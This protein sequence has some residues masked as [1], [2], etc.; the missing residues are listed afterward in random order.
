[1]TDNKE[2][3]RRERFEQMAVRLANYRKISSATTYSSLP[4]G[5]REIMEGMQYCDVVKPLMAFDREKGMTIRGLSIKY[6]L[7]KTTVA[8]YLDKIDKKKKAAS[9][10]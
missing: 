5:V 7:P 10:V 8:S 6:G 2:A 4:L 1:M 9:E 3:A